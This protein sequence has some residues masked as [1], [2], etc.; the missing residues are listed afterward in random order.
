MAIE[1]DAGSGSEKRV[2]SIRKVQANRQNA[3]KS[4][5]PRTSQGKAYSRRNAYKDG[6]FAMGPSIYDCANRE[7]HAR[8]QDL[9]NQLIQ[10]YK[11]VGPAE[12]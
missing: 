12:K 9:R 8:Y 2:V 1:T 6:L 7:D 11:P 3:L 4:T 5:G 10:D